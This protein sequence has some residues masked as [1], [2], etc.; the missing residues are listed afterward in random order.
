MRKII[1]AVVV[2][3]VITVALIAAGHP[4]ALSPLTWF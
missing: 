4:G 3:A 2:L 1:L